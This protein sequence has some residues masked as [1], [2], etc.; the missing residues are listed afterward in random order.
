MGVLPVDSPL[1]KKPPP[2]MP[3]PP[4]MPDPADIEIGIIPGDLPKDPADPRFPGNQPD[5]A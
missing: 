4:E 3:V 1:P 2:G 5:L